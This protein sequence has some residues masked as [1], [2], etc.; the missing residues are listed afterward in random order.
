MKVR[1]LVKLNGTDENPYRRHGLS[2]NPFPQ[3]LTVDTAG[4]VPPAIAE[5]IALEATSLYQT[6]ILHLQALGGEPVFSSAQIRTHLHGWSPAFVDL[7]C[8]KY[9]RGQMVE[10]WVEFEV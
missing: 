5:E 1:M 8:E 7:C 2:Q 3:R 6:Q 9:K 4:A 10:F